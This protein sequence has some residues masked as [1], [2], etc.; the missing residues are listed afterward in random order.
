MCVINYNPGNKAGKKEKHKRGMT[1]S[2]G[3]DGSSAHRGPVGTVKGR[4]ARHAVGDVMAS[5][6]AN[7]GA[8]DLS[9]ADQIAHVAVAAEGGASGSTSDGTPESAKG[10]SGSATTAGTSGSAPSAENVAER[11]DFA[12][13]GSAER[14]GGE[15]GDAIGVSPGRR[16]RNP[17]QAGRAHSVKGISRPE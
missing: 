2:C 6:G 5:Q 3:A 8:D 11:S 10:G 17:G 15:G 13:G 14:S 12:L 16:S 7:Q 9:G 1:R 4:R